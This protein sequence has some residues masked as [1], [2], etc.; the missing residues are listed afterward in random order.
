MY[1]AERNR[2]AAIAGALIGVYLLLSVFFWW[3]WDHEPDQFP[4]REHAAVEAQRNSQN[5]V[6][7]YIT[8]ATFIEIA[9]ASAAR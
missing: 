5:L 1:A 6:T 8:T 9:H 3:W 2:I 4:V 7:G